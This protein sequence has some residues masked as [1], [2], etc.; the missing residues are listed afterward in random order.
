MSKKIGKIKFQTIISTT[1]N[2][3][4]ETLKAALTSP[5]R[6]GFAAVDVDESLV[7]SAGTGKPGYK[8]GENGEAMFHFPLGIA[9]NPIDGAVYIADNGNSRI[10]KVTPQSEVS[11]FAGTEPGF[12]DGFISGA[13]FHGPAGLCADPNTGDLYVADYTNHR[14]RKINPDGHVTTLAGSGT[15]GCADG[16]GEKASFHFPRNIDIDTKDG[17]VYVADS[18]S[19]KIRKISPLGVVTTFAGSGVAGFEDGD[20]STAKFRYPTGVAVHAQTGD[21]YVVDQLNYR[22]RRISNGVVTTIAGTGISRVAD[23]DCASASF[24]SPYD[25][26]IDYKTDSL[27]ITDYGANKI[28]KISQGM[29]TTINYYD[30]DCVSNVFYTPASFAIDYHNRVGYVCEHGAHFMKQFYLDYVST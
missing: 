26:K 30:G 13:K 14:I 20:V 10:R 29:V 17:S 3:H 11:T 1:A 22:V 4:F 27:L 15:K 18:K 9:Y 19:F 8:D 24:H 2:K 7:C 5:R 28:R 12:Y 6:A 23:G 21:I 16:F 25:I